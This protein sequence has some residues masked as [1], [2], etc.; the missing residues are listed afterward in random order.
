MNC[1][2]RADGIDAAQPRIHIL[3]QLA[4]DLHITGVG[5]MAP[6]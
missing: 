1:P 3:E 4:E 6:R 2:R 5:A